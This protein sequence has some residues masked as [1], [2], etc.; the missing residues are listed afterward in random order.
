MKKP[1]KETKIGKF[2]T[3][4]APHIINKVGEVL[5][6]KGV[7]GIVKN[8]ITTDDKLSPEDKE[9]ALKLLDA[10]LSEMKEVSDRWKADMQSDSWLSK[11]VRP[12]VL[13]YLL[14]LLT[15]VVVVSFW[16]IN[17]PE[18]YT[19]L[20]QVLSTSVFIAY[21]GGRSFEKHTSIKK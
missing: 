17:I 7:F 3:E 1:F 13:L 16:K 5:P 2:L 21:F 12:I 8:L 9:M 14:F 4:K 10:E 15:L 11:N 20:L 19:S 18:E 6:D